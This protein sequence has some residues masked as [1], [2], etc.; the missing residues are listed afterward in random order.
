MRRRSAS[1]PSWWRRR[2]SSSTRSTRSPGAAASPPALR[3]RPLWLL[4]AY[5][6][7]N[8]VNLVTPTAT[9]GGEVVRAGMLPH[10]LAR[11]EIVASVT[12]DRLAMSLADTA[13][14][15]AGFAVLWA[16]G[17]FEGWARAALGAGAL[18]WR[19]ASWAS[20]CS[21]AADAWRLGSASTGW[22]HASAA[23]PSPSASRRRAARS[24]GGSPRSTPSGPATSAPRWRCTPPGPAV[25][26]LQLAIFLAWLEVPFDLGDRRHGVQR[27]GRPRPLLLLHP[28]APRR[29]GGV[30]DDRHVGGRPRPGARPAL[31]PGAPGGAARLGRGG[32]SGGADAPA[33]TRAESACAA[34]GGRRAG[35]PESDPLQGRDAC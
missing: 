33:G 18:R 29:P 23:P 10:G 6:A 27:G 26:A 21:S 14:G 20:C 13:I 25:G 35:A 7:G 11:S 28:R 8:A 9:L 1:A 24:T 16:R 17:P 12:A 4:R 15:L 3:P 2:R 34:R 30:A 5:L 32:L 19:R 22:S 31:L